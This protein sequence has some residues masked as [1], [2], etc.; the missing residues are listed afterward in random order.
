MKKEKKKRNVLY[1]LSGGILKEDFV[2]KHTRLIILTVI[3][4]VFFVGNRYNCLTKLREIDRLQKELQDVKTEAIQLSGQLTGH[5]RKSQ[6]E[7]M[8]KSKGLEIESAKTPPYIL[9]K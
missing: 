5:N 4:L 9:H 3:L 6:I 8:V 1:I 2:V 7:Q